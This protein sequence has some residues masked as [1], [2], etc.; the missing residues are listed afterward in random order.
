[1][2]KVILTTTILIAF[3]FP[4]CKKERCYQCRVYDVHTYWAKGNDTIVTVDNYNTRFYPDFLTD[5]G[6]LA[7]KREGIWEPYYIKR[8]EYYSEMVLRDSCH[9]TN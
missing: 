9:F 6:Y 7:V 3:L 1:M 8:C 2:R 4:S 5:S